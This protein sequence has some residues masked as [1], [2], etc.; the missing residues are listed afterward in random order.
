MLSAGQRQSTVLFLNSVIIPSHWKSFKDKSCPDGA[1][2]TVY[3]GIEQVGQSENPRVTFSGAPWDP[4]DL[5]E[6][7]VTREPVLG[8]S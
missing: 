6:L 1:A 5:Q 7:D 2:Q 3:K 4:R 8:W